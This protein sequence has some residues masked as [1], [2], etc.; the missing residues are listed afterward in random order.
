MKKEALRTGSIT[1]HEGR[2]LQE[3]ARKQHTPHIKYG[4]YYALCGKKFLINNFQPLRARAHI[5]RAIDI[6]P[7]RLDNYLFYT[8]SFLPERTIIWLYQLVR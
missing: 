4:S 3:M 8:L 5:A 7:L 1:A 6:H 2:L